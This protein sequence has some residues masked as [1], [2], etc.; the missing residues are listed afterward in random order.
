MG[1]AGQRNEHQIPILVAFVIGPR[2]QVDLAIIHLAVTNVWMDGGSGEYQTGREETS[3]G[4]SAISLLVAYAEG[5]AF[6][7]CFFF[8][9]FGLWRRDGVKALGGRD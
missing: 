6:L 3:T 5:P 7:V 4:I 8:S 9:L 1:F 2:N